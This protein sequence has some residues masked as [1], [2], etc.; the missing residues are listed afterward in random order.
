M[1]VKQNLCLFNPPKQLDYELKIKPN[2]EKLYQADPVHANTGH[3]TGKH[4]INNVL[5]KL[6]K[7]NAI[8]LKIRH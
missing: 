7:A 8:L 3:V 2:A 6:D 1:S 4:Q 5:I